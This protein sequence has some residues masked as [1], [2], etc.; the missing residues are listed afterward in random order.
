MALLTCHVESEALMGST[1][2]TAVVPQEIEN[3]PV[4]YL[5]HG[6]TDDHTAWSRFSSVE[7]YADDAGLAVVMPAVHNSFYTDEV[8][9]HPY[10]A[11][12]SEELPRLVRS[13]LRV[14]DRPED[15]F[16]AGLS[17]GGYGA[18]RLALTHPDRYAAAAS[19]S[20]TL[21]IH[22]MEGLE[23]RAAIF[24]RAFD[25]AIQDAN[26]LF[27]LLERAPSVPPLYIGCGTS[28]ALLDASER[29]IAAAAD[30]G[31]EVTSDLRPGDHDWK[32]WDAQIADVI[33]W[34][35]IAR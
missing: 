25:G 8:H 24:H 34:L 10:W 6:L 20:G 3:P 33:A 28:D 4:L 31:V 32:L 17:M 12:V 22:Y 30:A 35:P 9:G 26:D 23:H 29:F 11:Y 2:F 7:R 18:V 14:S 15:T 1:T 13:L 27:T 16:T 19:L 5:L 21:D